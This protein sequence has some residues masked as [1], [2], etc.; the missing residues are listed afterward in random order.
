MPSAGKY[1]IVKGSGTLSKF[2]E[3]VTRQAT[4]STPFAMLKWLRASGLTSSYFNDIPAFASFVGMIDEKGPTDLWTQLRDGANR[5]ESLTA[6]LRSAYREPLDFHSIESPDSTDLPLLSAFIRTHEG[7]SSDIADSAVQTLIAA[8]DIALGRVP[9]VS[10]RNGRVATSAPT[11][12]TPARLPAKPRGRSEPR[13]S[14]PDPKM[15]SATLAV[16]LQ[17]VLP[18]DAPNEKYDAML[19][20]V[21]RHLSPLLRG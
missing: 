15:L 11:P 17:I 8:F 21:A 18:A 3:A 20:A 4:P 1:P 14:N 7:A 19:G 6:A 16:N 9:A 13:H 12:S 2:F 10:S 5:K